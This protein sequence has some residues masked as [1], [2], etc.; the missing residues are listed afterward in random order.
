MKKICGPP[1]GG[2]TASS[3]PWHRGPPSRM[4]ESGWMGRLY[5]HT[6]RAIW[7]EP[8]QKQLCRV[9]PTLAWRRWRRRHCRGCRPGPR[10]P[11]CQAW[12]PPRRPQ[13]AAR[14]W[15]PWAACPPARGPRR[16]RRALLLQPPPSSGA[17]RTH[18][19]AAPDLPTTGSPSHCP[20]R[21]SNCGCANVKCKRGRRNEG[22]QAVAS[23]QE[24]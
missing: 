19:C 24:A 18:R 21:T 9:T 6:E 8:A 4:V 22:T 14:W 10:R 3:P 12:P 5:S 1:N 16:W 17:A 20:I 2:E 7:W 23:V 11:S 15:R 13:A